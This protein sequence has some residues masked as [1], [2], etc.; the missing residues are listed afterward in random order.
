MREEILTRRV[1]Q[2]VYEPNG[3][4]MPKVERSDR[5]EKSLYDVPDYVVKYCTNRKTE[6]IEYL[7][8]DQYK[9]L[10]RISC[11]N[12]DIKIRILED[13]KDSIYIRC[14]VTR[15]VLPLTVMKNPMLLRAAE[16][17]YKTYNG[18]YPISIQ[19]A[20]WLLID[21]FK[22]KYPEINSINQPISCLNLIR[23][24]RTTFKLDL[25]NTIRIARERKEKTCTV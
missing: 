5:N 13:S 23:Q 12:P 22:H 18:D 4:I 15:R 24:H 6:V 2:L 11:D 3:E 14:L 7:T 21:E 17:E 25:N 8:E 9:K 19:E 10:F 20:R 16:L 1:R